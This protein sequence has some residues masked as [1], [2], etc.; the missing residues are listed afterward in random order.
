M[1]V[2]HWDNK[3]NKWLKKN[4]EVCFEKIVISVDRGDLLE[5][6]GHPNQ[7]KYPW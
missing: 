6:V 1:K 5:I 2:F 3:K 7:G 4:K